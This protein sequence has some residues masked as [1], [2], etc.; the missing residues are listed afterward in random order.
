M[1]QHLARQLQVHLGLKPNFPD[2]AQHVKA[3][4][5][6]VS[7]T[8]NVPPARQ[9][10]VIAQLLKYLRCGLGIQRDVHFREK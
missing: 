10:D 8:P 2:L 5:D 4:M 1:A 9:G 7:R 3:T 6:Q